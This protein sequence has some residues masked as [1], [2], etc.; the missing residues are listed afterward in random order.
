[1]NFP[2]CECVSVHI[3]IPLSC[4]TEMVVKAYILRCW[5][6]MKEVTKVITL[7]LSLCVCLWW[8]G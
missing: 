4:D 7:S 1:M 2:L 8:M 5:H 6:R 3:K